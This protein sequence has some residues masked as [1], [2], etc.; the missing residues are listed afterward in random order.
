M[1]GCCTRSVLRLRQT[2]LRLAGLRCGYASQPPPPIH[3]VPL[4]EPL[5]T[6]AHPTVL[7]SHPF[8]SPT[9]SDGR[10][11]PGRVST[12]SNG[13]RVASQP[14]Y[15]QF[16][17]V[18]VCI[19][20]GS[21]Y[22]VAYP[23][24]ISHFLEKLAFASTQKFQSNDEIQSRLEKF[25]G[26][27]DCQSTRDTFLYAASIDRRGLETMVEILGDVVLRPNIT[28]EELQFTRMAV[29]YEVEDAQMRPDQEPLMLEAIHS[30][31][32][33][34]N[35]LGLPKM[36]P[37]EN[38]A[39]ISRSI[40]MKY[41]STYHVPSRMVVAG[42]GVEHDQLVR[43]VEDHFVNSPPVYE[44]SKAHADQSLAQYTGGLVSIE[45]D[46]SNVSLG[47][48]PMPDLVHLTIGLES[49]S[50]QHPNFIAFCVLNMMMG[51]GGS[52]SAGGPGKGM[53]TRLYTQVL[54]RYHWMYSATAFNH[55][56]G[57]SG[58]FCIT[59]SAP[60]QNLGDMTQVITHEMAKLTG[61]IGNEEFNRAKTQLKSMLLMNLE[62][63]PVIFEDVARQVLAQGERRDPREYIELI[64]QIQPADINQIAN[65]MLASQPSVA[66][67]GNLQNMPSLK[68]IELSLIDKMPS[69]S[70][71][72]F[73]R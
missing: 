68:D 2:Q 72:S 17:T 48:T 6:A 42:V 70:K 7:E 66:V 1:L 33:S 29:Q 67:I 38:T 73:F 46:L 53:Y 13:I 40:L 27:C 19:D 58:L 43:Y 69:P 28:E 11:E 34:N 45:K 71:R 52:F 65:K 64:D 49:V 18:G 24:G 50:H 51:G 32:F 5:S 37:P 10:A 61:H 54:N 36:C 55:A 31:A 26:I 56:Y 44:L 62:S 3:R 14:H 47:P 15:G 63:R 12:L 25:G 8:I 4:S 16:C 20:S 59:A 60:P 23:S 9:G 21:R 30:A 35:T 41:L 57:D 39:G 22:E